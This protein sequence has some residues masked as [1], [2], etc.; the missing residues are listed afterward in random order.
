L[1][2][3]SYG[4]AGFEVRSSVA[5]PGLSPLGPTR[6][7]P[8][9]DVDRCVSPVPTDGVVLFRWPGRYGLTLRAHGPGWLLTTTDVSVEISED[10]RWIGCH[11]AAGSSDWTEILVRRILPRLVQWH[12]H[13]ALHAATVADGDSAVV[14]VGPSGAG[15]STLAAALCRLG[16]WRL[17]SDD[18]SLIE[19]DRS[20]PTAWPSSGGLC[21]WPDS[22]SAFVASPESCPTVAGHTEK[23]WLDVGAGSPSPGRVA[24]IVMLHRDEP[25]DVALSRLAPAD[26]AQ[27]AGAQMIS[28]NPSDAARVA[29]T[30]SAVGRLVTEVP[31][32]VL[33]HPRQYERLAE[34]ALLLSARRGERAPAA[35]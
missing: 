28:F 9:I 21:L 16:P 23:R 18:I 5:L 30:W 20:S 19:V 7:A 4:L 27:M 25:G 22:L 3:F 24:A 2:R 13:V 32:Y 12:G 29:R 10:G 15:K 17:L 26:A 11:P 31:T 6:S 35:T 1:R 14:L 33:A 8:T 34:V